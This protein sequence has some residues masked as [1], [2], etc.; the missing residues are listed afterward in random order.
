MRSRIICITVVLSIFMSCGIDNLGESK[1]FSEAKKGLDDLDEKYKNVIYFDEEGNFREK[2]YENCVFARTMTTGQINILE[3]NEE[4]L[5]VDSSCMSEAEYL[6]LLA[7]IDK[8]KRE[9]EQ[10]IEDVW[11]GCESAF[12]VDD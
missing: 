6:D 4:E 9:L 8:R 12:G 5:A 11:N 7:R 2:S 10:D 1:C 3:D